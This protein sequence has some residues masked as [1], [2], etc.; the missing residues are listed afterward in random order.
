MGKT[1]PFEFQSQQG[2]S[3]FSLIKTQKKCSSALEAGYLLAHLGGC[4]PSAELLAST[5]TT[6]AASNG[7]LIVVIKLAVGYVS[8]LA[9]SPQPAG[10]FSRLH[11][12]SIRVLS[13]DVISSSGFLLPDVKVFI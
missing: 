3:W 4:Q 8:R 5:F 10:S 12:P 11:T 2:R 1:P 7:L 6:N 9:Y 13:S